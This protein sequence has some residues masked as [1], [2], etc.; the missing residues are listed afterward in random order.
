MQCSR[1]D[2]SLPP[3]AMVALIYPSF[4]L[5]GFLASG[6]CLICETCISPGERCSGLPHPCSPHEDTCLT[7]IGM[8]SLSGESTE[9]LKAC[10]TAASCY[11]GFISVTTNAGLH[12]ESVSSCCQYD[13]CNRWDLNL[14]PKNGTSNG[15]ECPVCFIFGSG[16]CEETESL[17]CVGLANHCITVSGTLN[18]GLQL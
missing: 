9:T 8:N 18:A 1:V 16:H 15:L 17:K 4:L 13:L 2:E 10:I 14:P 6:A 11:A 7:V 12:M 3:T 5:T